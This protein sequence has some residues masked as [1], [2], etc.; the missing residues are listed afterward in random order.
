MNNKTD[1]FHQC[2]IVEMML[3]SKVLTSL[4]VSRR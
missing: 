1:A 3:G 2:V 4:N